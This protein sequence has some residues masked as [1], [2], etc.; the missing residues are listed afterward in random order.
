MTRYVAAFAV[1]AA[2]TTLCSADTIT[3]SGSGM[4]DRWNTNANW[5]TGFAPGATQAASFQ[6]IGSSTV[7]NEVTNRLLY[8]RTV[9]GLSFNNNGRYHTT[10]LGKKTLT[11]KGDLN[12]N[13]DQPGQ[14]TTTFRNGVLHVTAP[15]GYVNVGRS[16]TAGA[17]SRV[18][19]GT[20]SEFQANVREF[21][22][23][24]RVNGGAY[25]DLTL[26]ADNRIEAGAM[27]L[28]RHATGNLH[29]GA[30][31]LI[32][33]DQLTFGEGKGV[34]NVDI[35]NGGALTVGSSDRRAN[36]SVAEGIWDSSGTYYMRLDLSGGSFDAWLNNLVIGQ[37]DNRNGAYNVTVNGGQG[38]SMSVGESG[39]T[40]Q[41]IV[42]GTRS[43]SW[44]D[45]SGLQSFDANLDEMLIGVGGS[46]YGNLKLAEANSIDTKTLTVGDG[47]SAVLTLGR[48]NT[49][50]ADEFVIGRQ[51]SHGTFEM[52]NDATL[53]LGTPSR[54]TNLSIGTGTWS[55]NG[56]YRSRFDASGATLDAYLD[57]LIVG[58]KDNQTGT[59]DARL[60]GGK[61]GSISVG[62]TGNTANMIVG[63]ARTSAWA[64]FSGMET[65]TANLDQL[66]LGT[67]GSSYGNVKLAD[68]NTIDARIIIVGDGSSAVLA[69]G[70]DNTIL[71]DEFA[72]GKIRSHGTVEIR[73][74]GTLNL[75]SPERR[76]NL[77][78]ATGTWSYNGT[79][80][81]ALDTTGATLN[82]YLDNLIVG[83]KDNQTG[84]YDARFLAGDHGFVSVG[85]PDDR[86]DMIVGGARSTA[87]VDFSNLDSFSAHL[88]E[89]LMGTGGSSH[90]TLKL[91]DDA[92]IDANKIVVGDGSGSVL[93]LGKN[94]TIKAD[95]FAI[96]VN[97]SHGRVEIVPGGTLTVGEPDRPTHL[98]IGTGTWS[99]NGTYRPGLD[100]SGA[101]FRAHLGSLVLG[102]KDNQTG[103]YEATLTISD[104][105]DNRVVADSIALGGVRTTGT[106]NFGGGMLAAGSIERGAGT[107][108]FNWTG[109]TLHVGTFGT[110]TISFAL[111]NNG[112]GVLAPG[113]S[114]G[115]TEIFGNYIQGP[116]AALQ[117]E[118]ESAAS[119]DQLVVHDDVSLDGSLLVD[120]TGGLAGD[121]PIVQYGALLGRFDELVIPGLKPGTYSIDYG[122]GTNDVITLSTV[123]EPSAIA[124]LL[125]ALLGLAALVRI[126]RRRK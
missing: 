118:L 79:Y 122:S 71:A 123:P 115:T 60:L 28:G 113:T 55:Y 114:I 17:W 35:V 78:I 1:L 32:L 16:Y 85:E 25:G 12:F 40:A 21:H 104:R 39:N 52:A 42:G 91:P 76:T 80:R 7:V 30:N 65:F 75:G 53:T 3:W 94:T 84:T 33:V 73:N 119:F 18:D 61:S 26:A 15:L 31:N 24:T 99:Y 23:G 67:G 19:L 101:T 36:L 112:D 22:I 57:N 34:S 116:F 126:R 120:V 100:L 89:L 64:D 124:M 74:R 43:T 54:R 59:Y 98:S 68:Q 10:D 4:N 83:Q 86:A 103:N 46:S 37:K 56:T 90:G 5:S 96:G 108:R 117:I 92:T 72:I 93:F 69:L 105:D 121:F 110:P 9:A 8:D 62:D 88:N 13:L 14:T 102:K 47:S 50:V 70:D 58:Q 48:D 97:R 81:S 106:L 109:G 29:L 38:G 66:L 6:N 11:V 2:M 27:I 95:Q 41:M 125:G 44:V 111:V 20:L 49:I 107:G 87:T 51:R 63:G 45:F 82:A 77:S